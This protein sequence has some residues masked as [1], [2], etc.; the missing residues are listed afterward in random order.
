MLLPRAVGRIACM[1]CLA[2]SICPGN[3]LSYLFLAFVQYADTLREATVDV[4]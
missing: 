4:C 3:G 2:H 1:K